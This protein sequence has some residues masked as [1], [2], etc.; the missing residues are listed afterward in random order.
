MA[1]SRAVELDARA[2]QAARETQRRERLPL[3]DGGM[4]TDKA[5][6]DL[7]P[8]EAA[9]ISALHTDAGR[10]VVDTGYVP[11]GGV[12]LGTAQGTFEA[13]YNDGTEVLLL[14]TTTTVYTWNPTVLQW[15]V[16]SLDAIRVTTASEAAGSTTFDLDDV[17]DIVNGSVVGI[18]LDDGT[19]L[20]TTVTNVAALV[21]TT[22]DAVPVGRS[23][24]LGA[25][26]FL[27][28]PLSGDPSLSQIS[29]VIFPGNDWIVFSNGID[30]VM[31]YLGGI[32]TELPG[33]PASTTCGAM[34]VYHELLLL[35]NMTENGTHLPSRVRQ[36]DA[37]DPSE[38]TTGIAAIYD[39]LDTDDTI[40]TLEPLG[41]WMIA[42]REFSIMRASYLGVLNQI[43]FWEYMSQSK[44]GLLG[45]GAQ[46]QG[47]VA[48]VGN[49]HIFVGHAGVYSY[50]GGYTLNPI[51]QAVFDNFLAASGDFNVPARATLFTAFVPDTQEVW[52]VY[53]AI[54]DGVGS[55]VP[56][57]MLRVQLRNKSWSERLFADPFYAAGPF[58]PFGA[59]TWA[60]A[61]GQWNSTEWARPW[62]SRAFLQNVPS[63]LMC[64]AVAGGAGVMLQLY[65]YR[66]RTDN[67]VTIPWSLVTKQLGDGSQFSRW[68]RANVVG[69]G[70]DVLVEVSEDEGETFDTVGT[71]D[72][73]TSPT[74]TA[75][76]VWL[77]RVSTRMQL[78]MS[79]SDSSF[80][81]RYVDVIAIAES[82]W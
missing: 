76:N 11:F 17:S 36:S 78:R 82:D 63:I 70:S 46:S 22:A 61:K 55:L 5:P 2:L 4:R 49:E 65:E 42:Y 53:P 68:E 48:N 16:T 69:I 52:V 21:I 56:N 18:V 3:L 67:G 45:E 44:N 71:F 1:Q 9:L 81:L 66:A 80:Q 60:N 13:F 39:L 15:Q 47:A 34:A 8:N 31:Y 33:L 40:L 32:I 26:V 25:E 28:V 51:G 57:K 50:Q 58:L 62:D 24:A 10:L 7:A 27:G 73:G 35:A 72:F 64:P 6:G 29:V 14:F 43:L 77:D 41:P 38:W 75:T 54:V 79:G 12:Y 30:P 74:P 20:I 37:G 23:V 59:T 19:Q